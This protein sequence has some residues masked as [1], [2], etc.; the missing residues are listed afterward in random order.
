MNYVEELLKSLYV[1]ASMVEA[2]DAYTGGHLWR[3]SQFS[4]ILATAKGLPDKDVA[5]IAMG[6]FLHDLG[7]IS[8]PDA[9]LGKTGRLTDKEYDVIK[10]HPAIGYQILSGHPLSPLAQDAVLFH[11]ERPDGKGYPQGLKSDAIS[12]DAKIVGITD[13]FDAMT[14]TRS[15]RR[16]MPVE[17][18][19]AIIEECAGSQ[20]D[21]ELSHLF[22]RLGR[23]GALDHTVGHSDTGIPLQKCLSCGPTIVIRREQKT[24]DY[25][26]CRPCGYRTTVIRENGSIGIQSLTK[27]M[28][29]KFPPTIHVPDAELTPEVDM[30][31]IQEL[32]AEAANLLALPG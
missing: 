18:A 13:A 11:H 6:G 16:G 30:P 25:V 31:L 2:R 1:M 8:V 24:G 5:R 22:I 12:I 27:N 26:Y 10:T 29:A 23:E 7:K 14:S 21:A 3:V 17:K 9:I 28:F 15:Y 32:V 20:F 19:L 4:K